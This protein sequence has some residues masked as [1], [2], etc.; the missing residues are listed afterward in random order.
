M[1]SLKKFKPY[2]TVSGLFLI[3]SDPNYNQLGSNQTKIS[4]VFENE[5]PIY[6]G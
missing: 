4:I 5:A 6:R 2:Q 1:K 3:L